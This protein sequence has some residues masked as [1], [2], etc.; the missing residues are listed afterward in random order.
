MTTPVLS[1]VGKSGSG[2]TAL[3]EKIITELKRRNRRVA[4]IK[5]HAH[6]GFNIDQPG[7]D[8]W[9]Y[10][11]AGSDMVIIAAPDKIALIE[12]L[13]SELSLD[14]IVS[15]ITEVDIILTEG[16]KREGK[17]AIEVVP[18][19][20]KPEII[21]EL[22]QLIGVVSNVQ[23]DLDVPRFCLEEINSLVDLI[24]ITFFDHLK[25]NHPD[26]R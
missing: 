4:T 7:K 15:R 10:A 5:H 17:P 13:D 6:V 2:K 1:I 24:E 25:R 11:R 18:G 21:C 8:S 20:G 9:R 16:F 12:I 14:E 23:L 19:N 22:N 3:L 26:K